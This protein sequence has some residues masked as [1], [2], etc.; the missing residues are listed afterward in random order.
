MEK[1][2]ELIDKEGMSIKQAAEYLGVHRSTLYKRHSEYQKQ[3]EDELK[4]IDTNIEFDFDDE[5][6]PPIPEK[7]RI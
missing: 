7:Y 4:N 2:Y 1:V 3:I 6:L 5:D